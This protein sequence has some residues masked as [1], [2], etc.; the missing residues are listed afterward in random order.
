MVE[1]ARGR[2]GPGARGHHL[3]VSAPDADGE[4]RTPA[5]TVSVLT[6]RMGVQEANISGNV[7]GGWLMKLCDDVAA[8]AATRHAG[9][10]VVTATVDGMKF[11]CPVHVGDVVTLRATVNAAWR[12]SMEV[13]V[14]VEAEDVRTGKAGHVCS[15]FLTMVALGDDGRP[16]AIPGLVPQ[17][18]LERQR[19]REALVRREARLAL[20]GELKRTAA[21]AAL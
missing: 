19:H 6:Q 13:G 7:H 2:S 9:G 1:P 20:S 15:A 3:G 10:R 11:V 16:A 21:A 5:D 12:T 8:V 18:E 4:V 14:R 17:S